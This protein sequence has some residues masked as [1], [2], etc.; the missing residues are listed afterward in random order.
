MY[1]NGEYISY[2][3]FSRRYFTRSI[4]YD[5]DGIENVWT[6]EKKLKGGPEVILFPILLI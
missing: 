5:V 1:N 4:I 6:T 3:F 2:N